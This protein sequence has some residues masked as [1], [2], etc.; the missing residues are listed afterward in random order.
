MSH[1]EFRSRQ[2]Y[3]VATGDYA[4]QV[5]I[6]VG[7]TEETVNCLS[8]PVMQNVDVPVK[9]F[10]TGRNTGIITMVENIPRKHFRVIKKQY[11]KNKN[12]TYRR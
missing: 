10:I 2:A 11:E 9:S 7:C 6:V 12:T 1:S 5:F 8:I 4:G 3:A